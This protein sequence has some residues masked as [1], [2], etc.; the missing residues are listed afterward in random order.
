[1]MKR[2]SAGLIAVFL[3][4]APGAALAQNAPV[5]LFID[6]AKL[7]ATSKAGQSI[8]EQLAELAKDAETS[9]QAEGQKVEAEGK[10]LQAAQDQLSKED[11]GKRYQALV[12]KAQ[13]VGRLEQIKKAEIAQ[14]QGKALNELN[15]H[16]QPV[17]KDILDKRK[18]TV[19]LERSAVIYADDDMDITDEIVKALDRKVKRVKVEK[20]DLLAQAEQAQRNR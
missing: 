6:Q 1:M 20:V 17:V 7:M 4:V 15:E 5:V 12:V 19:L 11:F 2:F 14:A 13:N 3:L 8:N 16:L 18:A 9:I 10:Q